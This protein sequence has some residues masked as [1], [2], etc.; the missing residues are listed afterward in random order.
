M[1]VRAQEIGLHSYPAGSAGAHRTAGGWLGLGDAADIYF[2]Q[3]LPGSFAVAG[4]ERSGRLSGRSRRHSIP[5]RP[6]SAV[7]AVPPEAD[8]PDLKRGL[9]E[10]YRIQVSCLKWGDRR[11]IRLSVQDYNSRADIDAL[12]EA[13]ASLLGRS[14]RTI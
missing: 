14:A 9:L 7:A 3:R 12:F 6:R 8:L 11:L 2:R 4:H 10:E 13:L 1:A 5:G